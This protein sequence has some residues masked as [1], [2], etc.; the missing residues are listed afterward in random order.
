VIDCWRLEA[1]IFEHPSSCLLDVFLVSACF[2]AEQGGVEP[3]SI[4]DCYVLEVQQISQKKFNE[5]LE[6]P[7]LMIQHLATADLLASVEKMQEWVK[8]HLGLLRSELDWA[9]VGLAEG[10]VVGLDLTS[11]GRQNRSER[12]DLA[13][14]GVGSGT[15]LD[16]DPDSGHGPDHVLGYG[17]GVFQA[18][19]SDRKRGAMFLWVLGSLGFFVSFRFPCPLFFLLVFSCILPTY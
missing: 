14:L 19:R 15:R 10:L 1:S 16:P 18:S 7:L 11:N 6:A 13:G 9:F 2:K 4:V 17:L 8:L 12:L 3:R 5:V